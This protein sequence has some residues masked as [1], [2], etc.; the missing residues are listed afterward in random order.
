MFH[1]K[2]TTFIPQSQA[3]SSTC[4]RVFPNVLFDKHFSPIQFARIGQACAI[5]CGGKY[6]HVFARLFSPIQFAK[7]GQVCVML[8]GG[9][10]S[11]HLRAHFPLYK[12][13]GFIGFALCCVGEKFP[14]YLRGVFPHI[15]ARMRL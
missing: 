3:C 10:Y 5:L 6:P 15:F 11:L 7:I 4:Q 14:R 8:C 13:Q 2:L 9:K 12:L 1:R